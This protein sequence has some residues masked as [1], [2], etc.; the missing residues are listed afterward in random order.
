[1][2]EDIF[3]YKKDVKSK[4]IL[5][6]DFATI[7]FADEKAKLIQSV[8]GSYSHQV[9][10]KFEAGSSALYWVS[11][12]PMG[13]LQLSRVVGSKG[14]FQSFA[15]TNISCAVLKPITV[16]LDGDNLCQAEVSNKTLKLEDAILETLKFSYSAGSL[17]I[18]EAVTMKVSKMRLS[19]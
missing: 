10:P 19:D 11:G 14:W 4:E 15:D 9:V 8:D 17:D 16:R 12:Q 7:S 18:T 3:G 13:S 2:S 1:M 6:A 5:S